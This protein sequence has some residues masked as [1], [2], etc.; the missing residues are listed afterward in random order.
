MRIST[1]ML[2]T[3]ERLEIQRNLKGFE[4][5]S[6]AEIATELTERLPVRRVS[7]IGKEFSTLTG[8][9]RIGKIDFQ[10]LSE[11]HASRRVSSLY[12]R[13]TEMD[14]LQR[15]MNKQNDTVA[16]TKAAIAKEAI[17]N[18]VRQERLARH[19]WMT[20][21]QRVV[22]QRLQAEAAELEPYLGKR[23]KMYQPSRRPR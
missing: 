19:A 15:L 3:L 16:R 5:R 7:L 10:L 22:A 18:F 6:Y 2:T 11:P 1:F 4:G 14:L 9:R 23:C 8:R 12:R 13:S 21:T 20:P 17:S